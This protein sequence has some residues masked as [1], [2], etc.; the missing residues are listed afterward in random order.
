LILV[1]HLPNDNKIVTA[2]HTFNKVVS[3]TLVYYCCAIVL[4]DCV[5]TNLKLVEYVIP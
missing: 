1:R 3:L 2:N 4:A 5:D